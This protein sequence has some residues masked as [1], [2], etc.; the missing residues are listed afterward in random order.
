MGFP[1]SGQ[2]SDVGVRLEEPMGTPMKSLY[3]RLLTL[4][5]INIEQDAPEWFEVMQEPEMHLWTG[6]Q[7]PKD[8]N[9]VRDVVLATYVHHPEILLGA[10]ERL[11]LRK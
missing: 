10:S 6:N 8:L 1:L 2:D 11:R 3:G 5:P 4:R 9:E 7:I